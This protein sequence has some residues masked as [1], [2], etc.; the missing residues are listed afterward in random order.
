MQCMQKKESATKKLIEHD[1]TN[2]QMSER[3]K[4]FQSAREFSVC[5]WKESATKN[6]IKCDDTNIQ[7]SEKYKF[8]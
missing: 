8:P 7:M 5:R 4:T 2:N 1:D 6:C 3:L